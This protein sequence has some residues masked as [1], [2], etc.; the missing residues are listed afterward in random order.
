MTNNW[1][2]HY[3]VTRL[4]LKDDN[5]FSFVTSDCQM[6]P[7]EMDAAQLIIVNKA[8]LKSVNALEHGPFDIKCI[9]YSIAMLNLRTQ[10]MK[11]AHFFHPFKKPATIEKRVI[12]SVAGPLFELHD[13][14]DLVSSKELKNYRGIQFID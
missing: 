6:I 8:G 4:V 9:E 3:A 13:M 5:S 12:R 7:L 10:K 11:V 2:Q 14:A 1:L